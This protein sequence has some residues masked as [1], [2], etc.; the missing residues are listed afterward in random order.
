MLRYIAAIAATVGIAVTFTLNPAEARDTSGCN[1]HYGYPAN[2]DGLPTYYYGG[3]YTSRVVL[4]P[5]LYRTPYGYFV[6]YRTVRR[7]W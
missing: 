3:F 6:Q 1:Q 2:Y 4:A 7:Y 5:C